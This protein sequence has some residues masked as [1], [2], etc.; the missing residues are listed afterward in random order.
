MKFGIDLGHGIGKDRGAVGNI[1]EEKIINE[2]GELVIKKLLDKGYDVVRLRPEG[3]LSVNQSLYE[4]Y[5]KSDYYNCDMCVSIHANAGGGV[6]TEVFTYGGKEFTEAKTVLNNI[7]NLGFRNR[8]IKDGSNLAMVRKPK[9]KAMLIEVC[10]VDSSDSDKYLSIGAEAIANA[11]VAG[12]TNDSRVL[13]SGRWIQNDEGWRYVHADGTTSKCK[14]EKIDGEWYYFDY[15]GYMVT[16]WI[17]IPSEDN[18]YYCYS[19]GKM[20][21]DVELWGTWRFDSHGVGKKIL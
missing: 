16:G 5:S 17:Y 1:A 18:T 11:I 20:A 8:G 9:A 14:W 19:D 21:H 13:N 12:L 7:V 4:R 6:G 15:K 10:F 3:N 2:V